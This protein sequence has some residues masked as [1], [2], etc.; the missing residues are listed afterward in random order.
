MPK[1]RKGQ[2]SSVHTTKLNLLSYNTKLSL[3]RLQNHN[4]VIIYKDIDT[5]P[6]TNVFFLLHFKAD[7]SIH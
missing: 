2:R 3:L 6:E 7:V 1:L 5:F 4:Y